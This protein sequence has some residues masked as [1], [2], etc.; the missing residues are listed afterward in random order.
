MPG[1]IKVRHSTKDPE[2]RAQELNNTGSPHPYVVEY[3]MLIEEPYRL[4]QQVHKALRNHSEAKEWF[5][6]SAEEA[7]AVIQRV[8]EGK[9]INETF[10]RVEREKAESI[11]KEQEVAELRRRQVEALIT[12]QVEERKSEY[13]DIFAGNERFKKYPFWLYWI[14]CTIGVGFV[15]AMISQYKVLNVSDSSAFWLSVIGGAVIAYYVNN[16]I[17]SRIKRSTEYKALIQEREAKLEEARKTVVVLCPQ[18]QQ[19]IQFD[20]QQL[21][22]PGNKICN[23]PKCKTAVNPLQV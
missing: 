17:E 14:A 3:E 8:A 4:E 22:S 19:A 21:L 20:V 5:R 23:C 7:I 1:L 15:L 2:L 12:R 16:H 9:A 10:K 11:R 18:C 13:R 6:C